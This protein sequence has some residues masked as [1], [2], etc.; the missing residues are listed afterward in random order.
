MLMAHTRAQAHSEMSGFLWKGLRLE[1]P[2]KMLI[3]LSF[4][5]GMDLSIE[6]GR[7]ICI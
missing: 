1:S 6:S 2:Q 5:Q 4:L 7:V 3:Y